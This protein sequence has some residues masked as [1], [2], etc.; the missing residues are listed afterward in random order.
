[1][2]LE[3]RMLI[4]GDKRPSI[5]RQ[6]QTIVIVRKLWAAPFVGERLEATERRNSLREWTIYIRALQCIEDGPKFS[7]NRRLAQAIKEG[8]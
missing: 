4:Y 2:L 7:K 5:E 8:S 3:K 1:M 6:Q